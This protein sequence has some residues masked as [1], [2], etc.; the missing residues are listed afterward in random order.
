MDRTRIPARLALAALL[1]TGCGA[2]SGPGAESIYR[3]PSAPVEARVDALLSVMTLEEKVAQMHGTPTLDGSGLWPTAD[4]AR[5]GIPGFR[6]V[7]GPRGVSRNAGVATAFPVGAARGATFDVA[8]ERRVGQAIAAEARARGANVLLAPTMNL[9][10]HPRWGRAQETYGEDS[11]HV[12]VMAAGFVQG[13]Q[14]HVIAVAKHFAANSIEDVRS[15]VDV[16]MDDRTL[17][18]VYLPHFRRAVDA[19]VGSVMT[20][21]NQVNGA[22]CAENRTLAAGILEGEWGFDGFVVSDWVFGT[23]STV[24]SVLAGLDLE[25]P[26][27]QYYGD[28]LVA[29]VRSGAAPVAAVDGAVRRILRAKVRSGILDGRASL[30]PAVEIESAP[31]VA[32]AREVAERSIVLLKND[33]ALPLVRES[34]RQVAVVGALA[35]TANTGDTGSSAAASSHVVTP[36]E[37]MRAL[38]G[39]VAVVDVARDALSPADQALVAGADAAVVVVG[40]TAADEGEADI[41]AG[42]RASLELSAPHQALVAEVAALNPRTIVILEGSGPLIVE[43]FVDRVP[44]IAMAWYPGREGGNAIAAVLFG[45]V[46]PSGRLPVSFPRAEAQLP[47]FVNDGTPVTYGYLHGYRHLDAAAEEPRFPFGSGLGY[48]TFSFANLRLDPA[49]TGSGGTVHVT[50]EVT[51]RGAVAGDEVVQLYV[52]YPGSAVTRAPRDLKG[53]ARVSLAPGETRTVGLDLAVRDLAFWDAA[54]GAF[55]VEPLAYRVQVGNGSRSLPLE[56]VLT[57]TP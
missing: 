6:M 3:D 20:A 39:G 9:V 10:R 7:D 42:D 31:H 53:F 26:W 27:A 11:F 22:Y 33:G 15:I 29:A 35:A 37:G 38:A 17:R 55:T 21:Y 54:R 51:N 16:R 57:V 48:T 56:A 47:P 2:T 19:G 12:G 8:L 13:A 40:L 4:D 23:R 32:L 24:P 34:I 43:G 45:D 18:E 25:M 30:D 28:P 41:G 52:G 14:E 49:T 1:A 36:L 50:V 5:L 44:A 46:N